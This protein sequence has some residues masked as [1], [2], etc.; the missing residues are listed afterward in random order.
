MTLL[1]NDFDFGLPLVEATDLL[2]LFGDSER[3]LLADFDLPFSDFNFN[4][5][6]FGD[7][8]LCLLG[9][10]D[11]PF[12]GDF[13]ASP[14]FFLVDFVF[15][16]DLAFFFRIAPVAVGEIIFCKV[17]GGSTLVKAS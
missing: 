5:D 7:F 1:S 8:D 3:L 9:D 14:F 15:E 13:D 11:F 17:G 16:R 12:F 10:F 6:F 2:I 4:F